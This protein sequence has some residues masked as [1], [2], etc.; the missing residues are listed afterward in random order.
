M[1][2]TQK[3]AEDDLKGLDIADLDTGALQPLPASAFLLIQRLGRF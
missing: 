2:D 1:S 3:K